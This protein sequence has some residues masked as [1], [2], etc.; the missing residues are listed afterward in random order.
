MDKDYIR[1]EKL[2]VGYRGRVIIGDIN[3]CL[4]K[5]QIMT[6][7]GPNGA[8]KS[9][10]LKNFTRQLMPIGGI[11]Y[12][13]GRAMKD[14]SGSELAKQVAMVMTQRIEPELMTCFDVV[15]TGRYPY[16]GKLGLLSESD[17]HKVNEALELVQAAELAMCHFSDVSD[18][19][20]QRI[21]LARAICQEPELMILDEPTS[22]LDIKH[23][24]E[25]LEILKKLVREQ[26]MTVM[27]SLHELDLAQKLSDVVVCVRENKIDRCGAP[28]EIFT[29]EYIRD[30]YGI[31]KG[32]YNA[33]LGFMELEPVAGAPQVFVIGGNGSGI[34]TYRKLHREGIAF[35]AGVLHE[36]DVEYQVAKELASVVI[37]EKAFEPIS[38]EHFDRARQVMKRCEKVICCLTEFG[39]MNEKNRMLY[40]EGCK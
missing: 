32:S 9:T 18:G 16:T 36:N 29:S 3:I 12:I 27:M 13:D 20:R 14:M 26:K 1:T 10:I 35:A 38:E 39:T 30:L 40:E 19:Q 21:M 4:K 31:T 8:G 28:Q 33:E 11:V 25:L 15:S 23:K 6:L 22:Y 7:I 37:T 34:A 17:R 5:G 2:S 24:L